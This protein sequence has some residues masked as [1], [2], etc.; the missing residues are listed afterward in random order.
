MKITAF[1]LCW[2]LILTA[3]GVWR[4]NPQPQA[5]LPQF[6]TIVPQLS[7]HAG[8]SEPIAGRANVRSME[9]RTGNKNFL[10]FCQPVRHG[11]G[12]CRRQNCASRAMNPPYLAAAPPA[13]RPP[14]P[15]ITM[16][17]LPAEAC[18]TARESS[19]SLASVSTTAPIGDGG[20]AEKQWRLSPHCCRHSGRRLF[21]CCAMAG[22]GAR[23]FI[24][25]AP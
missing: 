22:K 18:F 3:P 1:C 2:L 4:S 8:I 10:G 16:A 13:D 21:G 14:R 25:S 9:A 24:Y 7:N 15:F 20:C 23:T 17:R 19:L 6:L 5:N 12:R 11:I